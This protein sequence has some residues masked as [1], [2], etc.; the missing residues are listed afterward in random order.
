MLAESRINGRLVAGLMVLVACV[1][2]TVFVVGVVKGAPLEPGITHINT[3]IEG[4]VQINADSPVDHNASYRYGG[5][6][7]EFSQAGTDLSSSVTTGGTPGFNHTALAGSKTG[8]DFEQVADNKYLL[9]VSAQAMGDLS[10]GDSPDFFDGNFNARAHVNLEC[11]INVLDIHGR[12]FGTPS[13]IYLTMEHYG[14]MSN[15]N[16]G[17]AISDVNLEVHGFNGFNYSNHLE[18]PTFPFDA[19]QGNEFIGTRDVMMEEVLESAVGETIHIS[20]N[21]DSEVA[22]RLLDQDPIDDLA[23]SSDFMSGV[24][25]HMTVMPE[26]ATLVLLLLSSLPM[27]SRRRRRIS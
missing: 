15:V 9:T 21:L 4:N 24:Q 20:I 17:I 3:M 6:A 18:T 25:L 19:F 26:P 1:M 27:I 22:G 13:T 5:F 16:N 14:T 10:R 12:P 23:A 2:Q 7:K 8:V 11:D